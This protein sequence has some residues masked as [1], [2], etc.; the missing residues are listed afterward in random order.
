MF[1][2]LSHQGLQI[3]TTF[4]FHLTLVRMTKINN[5]SDSSHQRGCGIRETLIHYWWVYKFV[6]SLWKSVWQFLIKMRTDLSQDA[7]LPLLGIYTLLQRHLLNHCHCYSIC[8]SQKL[9]INL[10]SIQ[11]RMDKENTVH[12]Y[13]MEYNSAIKNAFM[14][15]S[16]KWM[17]LD[18]NHPE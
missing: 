17:E 7:V 6:Q 4:R 9:K 12:I 16:G 18:K 1:S 14:K 10:M 13:T 5:T 2:T 11:R 15:F 3:K 8:N